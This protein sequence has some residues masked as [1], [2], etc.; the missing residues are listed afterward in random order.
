MDWTPANKEKAVVK[1]CLAVESGKALRN[2]LK[3]SDMPAPATFYKWLETDEDLVKQYARSTSIRAE[4]LFEDMID[5]ADNLDPLTGESREDNKTMTSR[6][7]LRVDTRKWAASKLHPEKYGER[8][9]VDNNHKGSI[10]F[11]NV[12][13]QFPAQE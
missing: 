3:N 7:R 13:K 12:S 8:Y 1:I 5:I 9:S 10:E 11:M 6:D 2:I 4:S